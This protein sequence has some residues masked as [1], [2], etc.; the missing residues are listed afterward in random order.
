MPVFERS[1]YQSNNLFTDLGL[2]ISTGLNM[3]LWCYVYASLI[4]AGKLS[5][6]LPVGILSIF[7]G[8]ILIGTWV[9]LTSKE[10]LHIALPDDQGVVIFGSVGALM[11]SAM[12]ASALSSSGLATILCI[13]AL[14]T[15]AFS[16]S[17][18]LVGKY[19]FA[20]MLELL[21][22]PIICG[23]MASIGWLL[24]D[25][26]FGVMADS[27]LSLSVISEVAAGGRVWHLGLSVLLGAGLLSV[28]RKFEKSWTLPVASIVLVTGY[29]LTMSFLAMPHAEQQANGWL[30]SVNRSEGGALA[31]LS[32]LSP[33]D[34][35][36]DF[37]ATV[38]PQMATV[39]L[40]A[41]LY[42]SMTLTALKSSS[43]VSLSIA[44]EFKNIGCGNL[45]CAAVCSPAGFTE[46][47]TTVLFREFGASSRW[48]PLAIIAVGI[49]IVSFGSTI[50]EFLPKLLIGGTIFMFGL[51]VL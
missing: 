31:M 1:G 12:G 34:I 15:L 11:V 21:P 3:S 50:I 44:D 40:L 30:F 43:P 27:R 19:N 14:T 24:L 46:V 5:V 9:A 29:Y 45:F 10:P 48:M 18:Y 25:A 51:Q 49:A 28:T 47:V 33:R 13:I 32:A 7:L 22:Y 37:V 8:W 39:L 2:G 35:D 41:L 26:G 20:R 4:F 42:A 36:W 6:F 38:I 23:F 16:I 17:C